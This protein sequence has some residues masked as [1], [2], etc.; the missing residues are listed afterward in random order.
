MCHGWAVAQTH[1]Y[2]DQ[3]NGHNTSTTAGTEADPFKSITYAISTMVA[4]STPDPW[5]VHIKAGTYDA[6]PAKPANEHEVFPIELRSGMTLQGDDGAANC[7]IS[8]AFNPNSNVAL[9]HGESVQSLVIKH[10]TL[11]DMIRTGGTQYGG[12]AELVQCTGSVETCIFSKDQALF[13]GGLWLSLAPSGQFFIRSNTFSECKVSGSYV[14]TG[15]GFYVQGDLSGAIE[16]NTFIGNSSHGGAG[17]HVAGSLNGDVLTNTFVENSASRSVGDALYYPAIYGGG[18]YVSANLVGNVV[19]N[20]F[21][22]NLAYSYNTIGLGYS[23]GGAF[24]VGGSFTGSIT[25]NMFSGNLISGR[26]SGC[27][28]YGGAIC[29]MGPITGDIAANVYAKNINDPSVSWGGAIYLGGSSG[30]PN[31]ARIFNNVFLYNSVGSTTS[32]LRGS[33]CY[34]KQDAIFGW[35]TF[36]GGL[37]DESVL[38]IADSAAGSVVRGNI[39]SLVDTAIWEEGALD[40]PITYNDFDG[41][42]DVLYRNGQPM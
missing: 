20:V 23:R 8:G 3:A 27:E 19:S 2:I 14:R 7:V 6:D 21:T 4:R 35:N 24:Y 37:I 28:S 11:R 1:F 34:S 36:V 25:G 26:I 40:L 31:N 32:K 16:G 33:A 15:G 30:D 29:I 39:F 13:G 38:N 12:G 41:A 10:L 42:I 17:F 5:V 22:R 9:V 18:F